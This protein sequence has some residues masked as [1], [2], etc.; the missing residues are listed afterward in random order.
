[1]RCYRD[2]PFAHKSL[3]IGSGRQNIGYACVLCMCVLYTYILFLISKKYWGETIL[4]PQYPGEC[5][6]ESPCC[7]CGVGAYAAIVLIHFQ[8]FSVANVSTMSQNDILSSKE[9]TGWRK[10]D[11][12]IAV[13]R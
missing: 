2:K 13:F 4:S 5:W 7:L 9:G 3:S 12:G 11:Q 6:G 8:L 1:M 10:M